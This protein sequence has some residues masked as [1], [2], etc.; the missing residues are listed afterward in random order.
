[1]MPLTCSYAVRIAPTCHSA[2]IS[3]VRVP[4]RRDAAGPHGWCKR[5]DSRPAAI[6]S[7]PEGRTSSTKL[8]TNA[9]PTSLQVS[10]ACPQKILNYPWPRSRPS[11][12]AVTRKPRTA[13]RPARLKPRQPCRGCDLA[14]VPHADALHHGTRAHIVT[15]RARH[16]GLHPEDVEG[17]RQPRRGRSQTRSRTPRTRAVAPIRSRASSRVP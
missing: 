4:E 3:R 8:R 5:P 1:M 17:I 12:L 11:L 2:I 9:R 15:D 16:H 10:Q 7:R 14:R 6:R 13:R